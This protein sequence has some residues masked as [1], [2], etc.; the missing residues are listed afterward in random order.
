VKNKRKQWGALA[1]AAQS[2][3][4]SLTDDIKVLM[5]SRTLLPWCC[6]YQSK[7]ST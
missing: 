6:I 7:L 3:V 2:L 4:C 1:K 5:R